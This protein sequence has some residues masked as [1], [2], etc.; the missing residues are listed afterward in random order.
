MAPIIKERRFILIAVKGY[1][2]VRTHLNA[3]DLRLTG[4]HDVRYDI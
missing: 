1:P 3:T 2:D 4:S